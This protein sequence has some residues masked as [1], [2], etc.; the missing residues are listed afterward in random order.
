MA[1]SGLLDDQSAIRA[2]NDTSNDA[3]FRRY[4]YDWGA[5]WIED[6]VWNLPG[7]DVIGR[8]P[9]REDIATSIAVA[10][11]ENKP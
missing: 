5:C 11:A 3:V 9:R 1:F 10:M 8:N 2:L 7:N 4:G 6:S